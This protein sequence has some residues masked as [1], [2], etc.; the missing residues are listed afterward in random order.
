V[1]LTPRGKD[2]VKASLYGAIVSSIF[3]VRIILALCLALLVSAALSE[4]ILARATTGNT[5]VQFS[6]PHLT[7]F[8]EGEV[9]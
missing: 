9:R 8:K 1:K 3:D 6:D 4:I 7:C 2:Y 5:Q